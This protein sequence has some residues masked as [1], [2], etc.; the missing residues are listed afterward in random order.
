MIAWMTGGN[1]PGYDKLFWYVSWAERDYGASWCT[2]LYTSTTWAPPDEGVV[3]TTLT[4]L[5]EAWAD[6]DW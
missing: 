5:G 1:N 2:F 6:G 3:S 4:P